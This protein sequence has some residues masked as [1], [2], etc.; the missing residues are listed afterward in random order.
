MN[1]AHKRVLLTG[2][3]AGIGRATA[4]ELARRGARVTVCG[5]V[6]HG[7]M[8]GIAFVPCDLREESQRIALAGRALEEGG[9]DILINNAATQ[10]PMGF[11]HPVAWDAVVAEIAVNLLAPL[12]LTTL[13]LPSLTRRDEASVVNV[14]SALALVPKPGAPVYCATK[15]ALRA[16]T[17]SLRGQ[18]EGTSV[19]LVE[20]VPPLVETGM[21][22]GR[23]GRK[24]GPER[25]ARAIADGL[26]LGRSEV[27]IGKARWLRA[28]NRLAPGIAAGLMKNA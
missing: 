19:R 4:L 28:L 9:I 17:Q 11:A 16:F 3:T 23:G 15:A 6:M 22:R 21:T 20:I 12:H 13:L 24:I 25:V 14:T 8:P 18:L 1:L 10:E 7:A 27:I 26:E 5:R 2:G